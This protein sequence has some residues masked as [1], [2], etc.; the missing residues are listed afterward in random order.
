MSPITS[1]V[2]EHDVGQARG[3]RGPSS[4]RSRDG[5]DR[6]S[7]LARAVTDSAGR[8]ADFTRR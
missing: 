8:I 1:H 4:W 2:L 7:E 6:W 3:G 5:P